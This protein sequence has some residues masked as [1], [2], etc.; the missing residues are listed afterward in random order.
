[1]NGTSGLDQSPREQRS[2]AE[3]RPS[4]RLARPVGLALHVNARCARARSQV[5]ALT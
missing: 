1:M 3:R 5:V 2:L 4:V